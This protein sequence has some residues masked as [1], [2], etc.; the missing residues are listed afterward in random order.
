MEKKT[1]VIEY[2]E[3]KDMNELAD[4]ERRLME[5]AMAAAN[6]AYAPYSGF[7]VGAAVL[8]SDGSVVTGNNQENVAYPSGLCAERVALFSASAQH[9]DQHIV[10]LAVVGHNQ[11]QY[12]EASPCGACR[13]VMAEYERRHGQK[14][15]VLCYLE[16]GRIRRITGVESLLPFNFEAQ[17]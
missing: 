3:Y 8:L 10:A 15:T 2:Y 7:H 14:M 5:Q 12:C 13:Q 17:L 1:R 11:E 6:H 16:G 4:N 9:P